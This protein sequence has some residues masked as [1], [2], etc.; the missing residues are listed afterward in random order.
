MYRGGSGG[1]RH[2]R[3]HTPAAIDS[4]ILYCQCVVMMRATHSGRFVLYRVRRRTLHP[5]TC[6]TRT[7][8]SCTTTTTTDGGDDDEVCTVTRTVL[9]WLPR[10][11]ALV[12]VDARRR[13]RR[14]RR[15]RRRRPRHH[16]QPWYT[17][18][19]SRALRPFAPL[20]PQ[21]DVCV[22]S[23]DFREGKL[24]HPYYG[25]RFSFVK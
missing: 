10:R 19:P 24:L 17:R 13:R 7:R 5:R 21:A 14:C 18:S 3:S 16:H 6:R 2:F 15:R 9:Y 25:T 1:V 11:P 8:D 22:H 4:K 23:A 20:A 12:I